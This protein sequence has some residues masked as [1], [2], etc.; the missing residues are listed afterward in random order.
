MSYIYIIGVLYEL[1]PII[2]ETLLAL[3]T[4]TRMGANHW[5]TELIV[6]DNKP[7]K[8]QSL[9]YG[10]SASSSTGLPNLMESKLII[11]G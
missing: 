9:D 6:F 5:S 11:K 4:N 10:C 2:E 7:K 1:P 3:L 8:K